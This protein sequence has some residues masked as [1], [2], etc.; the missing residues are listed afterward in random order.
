MAQATFYLVR[1][2]VA[3]A[4]NHGVLTVAKQYS[5]GGTWFVPGHGEYDNK[6]FLE[7]FEIVRK[8]DLNELSKK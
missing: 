6:E 3:Y 8:L 1:V 2:H 7:V 4:S 5:P